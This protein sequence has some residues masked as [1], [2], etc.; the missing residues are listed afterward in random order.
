MGCADAPVMNHNKQHVRKNA[1][2]PSSFDEDSSR[3][4]SKQERE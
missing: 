1:I 4:V 3:A 2:M